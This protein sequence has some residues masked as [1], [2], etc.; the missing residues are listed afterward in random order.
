MVQTVSA[1]KQKEDGC[2][3]AAAV[4]LRNRLQFNAAAFCERRT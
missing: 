4:K 2:V 1:G 3:K